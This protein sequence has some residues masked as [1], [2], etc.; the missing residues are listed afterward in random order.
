MRPTFILALD[1]EGESNS[2]GGD[3]AYKKRLIIVFSKIRRA[4]YNCEVGDFL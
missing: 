4:I 1:N 2:E 3:F